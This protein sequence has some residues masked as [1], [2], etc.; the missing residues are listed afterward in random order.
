M[1]H[2]P[3]WQDIGTPCWVE[4][5]KLVLFRC[6]TIYCRNE[7]SDGC[8]N[9]SEI[10]KGI[11]SISRSY[12][13]TRRRLKELAKNDFADRSK[14]AKTFDKLKDELSTKRLVKKLVK[15][16]RRQS[17]KPLPPASIDSIPIRIVDSSPYVHYPAGPDDLRE[18]LHRLPASLTDGLKS[19]KL[20]LARNCRIN[21]RGLFGSESELTPDPYIGR[22]GHEFFSGVYTGVCRGLYFPKISAIELLAYVYSPK[23]PHRHIIEFYLRLKM[24]MTFVHELGHHFDNTSRIARGRWRMDDEEKVEIYAEHVQHNWAQEYIIPYLEQKYSGELS[25][26]NS[27]I[28]KHAGVSV[29]LKFISGDPRIT[30]PGGT[31]N[32]NSLFDISDAFEDFVSAAIQGKDQIATRIEFARNIH[33]SDEYKLPLAILK[34]VLDKN[35]SN[36]EAIILE[37]DIFVHQEKFKLARQRAEDALRLEPENVDALEVLA[38]AFEGL[39]QW[40]ELERVVNKLIEHYKD[41]KEK[42]FYWSALIQRARARIGQGDY[43]G[44]R[45]DLDDAAKGSPRSKRKKR[46]GLPKGRLEPIIEDINKQLQQEMSESQRKSAEQLRDDIVRQIS[47]AGKKEWH[48]PWPV[49]NERK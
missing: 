20:C 40:G 23:I 17:G 28:I 3:F 32:T 48:I 49:G 9:I 13:T 5:K 6:L 7:S 1:G 24:L 35:P 30:G 33:Y 22:M 27:W 10:Q 38:D 11:K 45:T 18:L 34:A 19:V 41:R 25:G 31:I 2:S 46:P 47:Q 14:K 43:I 12:H 16:E 29:P 44:G 42:A 21:S 37:G 36:I 4:L 39:K 15:N 8:S 26:F